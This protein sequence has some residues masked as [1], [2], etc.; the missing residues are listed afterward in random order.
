MA[1]VALVPEV[2]KMVTHSKRTNVGGI[3]TGVLERVAC[4]RDTM[5]HALAQPSSVACVFVA[6]D[7]WTTAAS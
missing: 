6:G 2:G 5:L 7:G 1:L 4:W 3:I